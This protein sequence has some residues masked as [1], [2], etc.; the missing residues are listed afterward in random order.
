MMGRCVNSGLG[1]GQPQA[2][3]VGRFRCRTVVSSAALLVTSCSPRSDIGPCLRGPALIKGG[4]VA[5]AQM[6]D[7]NASIPTPQPV[8]PRPMWGAQPTVASAPSV[9]FVAPAAIEDG[10]ANR[11]QVRRRL[12][13]VKDVRRLG[14]ADLPLNDATPRIAVDASTFAR[15]NRR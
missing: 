1:R 9:H 8:L 14:K 7:A 15:A 4:L 2:N 10:L 11:L 6:G 12:A 3:G 13:P 5:S